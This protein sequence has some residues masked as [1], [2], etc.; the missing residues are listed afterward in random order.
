MAFSAPEEYRVKTGPLSTP[1]GSGNNGCFR[2]GE[3]RIVSKDDGEWEH[4]DI[5]RP[6]RKPTTAEVMLVKGLFWSSTDEIKRLQGKTPSEIRHVHLCRK[7]STPLEPG[8]PQKLAG[9]ELVEMTMVPMELSEHFRESAL[10]AC[11]QA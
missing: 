4:L 11:A 2:I 5:A 1:S 3:L 10:K 9:H 8:V 6:D 7:K